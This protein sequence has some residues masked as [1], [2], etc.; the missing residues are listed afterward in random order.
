MPVTTRKDISAHRQQVTPETFRDHKSAEVTRCSGDQL[1]SYVRKLL[2]IYRRHPGGAR[3]SD[4][5]AT[6]HARRDE[7][8][9]R[10]RA[11]QITADRTSPRPCASIHRT[12]HQH[13]R[14]ITA[15]DATLRHPPRTHTIWSAHRGPLAA[16]ATASSGW[17]LEHRC[18]T[19][20]RPADAVPMRGAPA[21]AARITYP[22]STTFDHSGRS[23]C[24]PDRRAHREPEESRKRHTC[25]RI[26]S[27]KPTNTR[28]RREPEQTSRASRY[29]ACARNFSAMSS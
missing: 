16:R 9:R 12:V 18:Q 27:R 15:R 26:L 28:G 2:A 8:L 20:S 17:S 23:R 1:L 10:S 4:R 3:N 11:D 7:R 13:R 21:F 29:R 19:A 6:A 25:R 24:L 22:I 14:M 5:G